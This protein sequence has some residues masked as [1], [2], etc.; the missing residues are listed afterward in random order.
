MLKRQKKNLDPNRYS[1]GRL[2]SPRDEAIDLDESAWRA[3]L[4]ETRRPWRA[5]PARFQDSRE[6]P[7]PNGPAIRRIRGFGA[8]G[9]PPHPE[10]GLLLLYI[11]D[12]QEAGLADGTPPVVAFGISFPD[13]RSGLKVEY[14]V[15]NIL[16]EQEYG[17]A[18]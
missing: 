7:D 3:A 10:R 17:P 2:L 4:A 16:W 18:E 8:E 1:I 6:P 12:P 14:K 9:V 15:N 11:L 5:D 13:S